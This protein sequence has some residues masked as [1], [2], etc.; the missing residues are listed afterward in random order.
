MSAEEDGCVVCEGGGGENGC[1]CVI[2]E[3][4]RRMLT[5]KHFFCSCTSVQDKFQLQEGVTNLVHI[6]VPSSD[7]MTQETVST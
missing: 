2:K 7:C 1:A 3:G 4:R 6:T 5:H